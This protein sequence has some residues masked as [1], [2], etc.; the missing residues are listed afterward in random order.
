M[1]KPRE[2]W[3]SYAKAMV[4]AYPA[5]K[6]EY[7]ALHRQTVTAN[8]SDMPRGGSAS[9]TTEDIALRQLPPAKQREYDSVTQ[10]IAIT[11]SFPNGD[12]RLGIIDLVLWKK[13]HTIDGAA[14]RLGCS[15]ATAWRYH[16]DFIKLVG[17][18]HKLAD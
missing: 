5:L 6:Q 2:Y 3:W 9:R 10:A 14:L 18:F 1:S 11:R 8:L 15:Q 17:K 12:I 13:T 4:R 16:R 7:D